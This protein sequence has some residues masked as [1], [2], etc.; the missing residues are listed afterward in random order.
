MLRIISRVG[1]VKYP[2]HTIVVKGFKI[3]VHKNEREL[4]PV[5]AAE[6][7]VLVPDSAL[8]LNVP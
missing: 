6:H 2:Q 1:L 8:K 3:I 5:I 4:G 7:V